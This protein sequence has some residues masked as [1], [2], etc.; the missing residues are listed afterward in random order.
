MI[1]NADLITA[2]ATVVL[3]FGN[4]IFIVMLFRQIKVQNEQMRI[5]NE[6][7]KVQNKAQ[8]WALLNQAERD[9]DELNK[10]MLTDPIFR[11]PYREGEDDDY[12]KEYVFYELYYGYLERTYSFLHSDIN[13]YRDEKFIEDYWNLL[14]PTIK[15]LLKEPMFCDVHKYAGERKE[16]N[17]Y[18]IS[19]VTEIAK[20]S[21][22]ELK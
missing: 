1:I 4:F 9:F 22:I 6:Q 7:L 3:A 17:K 16:F 2:L 21:G 19:K 20:A 15:W 8:L 18:F 13:P 10:L 14:K 5:Q 12:A 11:H